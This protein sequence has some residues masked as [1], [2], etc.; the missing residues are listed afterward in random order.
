MYRRTRHDRPATDPQPSSLPTPEPT[1]P[2]DPQA[3]ITVAP[4][5]AAA[6]VAHGAPAPTDAAAAQPLRPAV[7]PPIAAASLVAVDPGPPAPHRRGRF[8]RT[9]VVLT[10]TAVAAVLLAVTGLVGLALFDMAY[11]QFGS[12]PDKDALAWSEHTPAYSLD[13]GCAGCHTVEAGH[14]RGSWHK[15]LRCETCHGPQALHAATATRTELGDVAVEPPS[16]DI[17]R[18]CHERV[19]G[20]PADFPQVILST[21][22]EGA[23][24]AQCHGVHQIIAVTPPLISHPRTNLPDCIVCH[25]PE[26]IKGLPDGHKASTDAVCMTCHKPGKRLEL[27]GVLE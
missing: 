23:E 27:D 11:A 16:R 10:R 6:A 4:T 8:R 12:H 18:R 20:R 3:A 15:D 1:T 13:G 21:H 17:C 7:T 25:A 24:C 26:G 2:V 22:Y 14:V 5:D 19:A 9:F